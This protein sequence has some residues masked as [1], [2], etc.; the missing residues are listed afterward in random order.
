MV[1]NVQN[2][3]SDSSFD[4]HMILESDFTPSCLSALIFHIPVAQ[5]H[6]R[7]EGFLYPQPSQPCLTHAGP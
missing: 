1:L 2:G 6:V 4:S 3:G 5:G 7:S